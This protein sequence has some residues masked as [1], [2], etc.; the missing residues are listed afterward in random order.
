LPG[1]VGQCHRRL[2]GVRNP[3]T[4][5][6]LRG[7]KPSIDRLCNRRPSLS[8]PAV[9]Q[10]ADPHPWAARPMAARGVE[11][12]A[13]PTRSRRSQTA[14]SDKK[15]KKI[16]SKRL[17][18][19]L[20]T[21]P[22][23]PPVQRKTAV[24]E[25]GRCEAR[26]PTCPTRELPDSKLAASVHGL[27]SKFAKAHIFTPQQ[28]SD[29]AEAARLSSCPGPG[30]PRLIKHEGHQRQRRARF[31]SQTVGFQITREKSSTAAHLNLPPE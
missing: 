14:Q 7:L 23:L 3:A 1:A 2:G 17:P 25:P 26:S 27:A 10:T 20:H 18:G 6:V 9:F 4:H 24:G 15:I 16:A 31:R 8:S 22:S 13:I 28:P 30:Y 5:N 11:G 29:Y 21:V 19:G 12:D